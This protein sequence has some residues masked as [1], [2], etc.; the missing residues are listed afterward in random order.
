PMASRVIL[1]P[2]FALADGLVQVTG[3]VA[4]AL[5]LPVMPVQVHHRGPS[6]VGRL[7][8]T[9]SIFIGPHAKTQEDVDGL[10]ARHG[11]RF[12]LR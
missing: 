8:D 7:A 2:A 1:T 5:R 3:W 10:P 12:S 6:R 9:M 11:Y 4:W